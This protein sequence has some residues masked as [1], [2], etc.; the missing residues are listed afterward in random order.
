VSRE[1]LFMHWGMGLCAV[2][3]EHAQAAA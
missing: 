1:G 3:R 2:L